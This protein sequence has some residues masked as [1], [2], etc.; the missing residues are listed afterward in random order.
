MGAL[1]DQIEEAR[2][3]LAQLERQAKHA[4]C[5]DLGHD[6]RMIGG[7]N[8]GCGCDGCGCSVPV[9]ECVRCGDC[10]YGDNDEAVRT[11]KECNERYEAD[12]HQVQLIRAAR[13]LEQEG[14]SHDN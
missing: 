5:R 4:S 11:V 12:E 9:N 7:K 3:R 1:A 14:S 10:D 6:W 2:N 8:A 13:Q